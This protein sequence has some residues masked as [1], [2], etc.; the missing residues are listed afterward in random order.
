MQTREQAL[1]LAATIGSASS[2]LDR[3]SLAMGGLCT[4][5]G[6]HRLACFDYDP[7]VPCHGNYVRYVSDGRIENPDGRLETFGDAALPA[8]AA[9]DIALALSETGPVGRVATAHATTGSRFDAERGHHEHFAWVRMPVTDQR[10]FFMGLARRH[11]HGRFEDHELTDMVRATWLTWLAIDGTTPVC[12]KAPPISQPLHELAHA[13][14][15]GIA[16]VNP[17]REVLFANA[18]LEGI[19]QDADGLALIDNRLIATQAP[20]DAR[21]AQLVARA[22]TPGSAVGTDHCMALSRPSFRPSYG[23]LVRCPKMPSDGPPLAALH[24]S[25]SDRGL[26]LSRAAVRAV[27]ELTPT[28]AEISARLADGEDIEKIVQALGI[29]AATVRVH[30]RNIYRKT[31]ITRQSELVRLVLRSVAL[32][33]R[34]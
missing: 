6:A 20:D 31:N 25:D 7:Q 29:R 16:I 28:E 30:L 33:T 4:D 2:H 8:C 1:A 14:P 12:Q 26:D 15:V 34:R 13:V 9:A 22:T 11:D 5:F 18:A 17:A 10:V 19:L 3:I 27:L 32:F 21:L 24:V 23:I